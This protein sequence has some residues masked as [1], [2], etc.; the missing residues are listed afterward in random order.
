[1]RCG[2]QTTVPTPWQNQKHY[3][4]GAL[5][6]HTGRLVWVEHHRKTPLFVKLLEQLRRQYRRAKRVVLI[7]DNYGI[8]K[9]RKTQR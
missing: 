2:K 4:A 5:H 9:R 7:L 1:M 6:A 8:H 3:L